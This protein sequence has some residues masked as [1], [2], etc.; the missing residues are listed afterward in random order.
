MK[1]VLDTRFLVAHFAPEDDA[2][3]ER[4]TAR[5]R[6]IRRR[7]NGVLPALVLGEFFNQVCQRSGRDSAQQICEYLLLSGLDVVPLRPGT[8]MAAGEIRCAHRR[9]PMGDCVVAALAQELDGC[10]VSDDPHFKEIRGLR[11]G[12]I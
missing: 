12:W 2:M 1:E 3:R 11:V 6:S 4:T 7:G 5:M 8:A 9:V 10:V